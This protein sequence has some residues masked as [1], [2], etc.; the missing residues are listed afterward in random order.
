MHVCA[1][2]LVALSTPFVER[3]MMLDLELIVVGEGIRSSISRLDDA[4]WR[5]NKMINLILDIISVIIA[6]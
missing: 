5:I 6:H 3:V 2:S 4:V 1:R